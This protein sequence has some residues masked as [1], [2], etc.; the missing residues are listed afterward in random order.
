[1]VFGFCLNVCFYRYISL[2]HAMNQEFPFVYLTDLLSLF[3]GQPRFWAHTGEGELL[4]SLTHASC[5]SRWVGRGSRGG[6]GEKSAS[7]YSEFPVSQALCLGLSG[8]II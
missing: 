2:A 5:G 4:R 3:R 7:H 8:Y 6:A 1:M